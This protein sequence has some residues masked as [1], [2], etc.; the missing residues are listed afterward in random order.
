MIVFSAAA[1]KHAAARLRARRK[2]HLGSFDNAPKSVQ[3][4]LEAVDAA[5]R[6]AD[7]IKVRLERSR[8]NISDE[9]IKRQEEL[10]RDIED[11]LSAE[12][13]LEAYAKRLETL[14]EIDRAILKA[15]STQDIACAAVERLRK[16]LDIKRVSVSRARS[17]VQISLSWSRKLSATFVPSGE[18]LGDV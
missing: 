17:H 12:Q 1:S 9:L 6:E 10:Q 18:I 16:V 15:E 13:S 3:A 14:H 8:D 4:L 11:R 7:L 5:Y 2:R